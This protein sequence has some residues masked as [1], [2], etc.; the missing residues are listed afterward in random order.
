MNARIHING[1]LIRSGYGDCDPDDDGSEYFEAEVERV[2]DDMC[3]S[4]STVAEAIKELSEAGD[5]WLVNA[6]ALIVANPTHDDHVYRLQMQV[7]EH[8]Y[9]TR[10]EAAERR[11]EREWAQHHADTLADRYYDERA[12]RG[13]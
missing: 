13:F 7:E 10:R 12:D 8:I 6:L 2:L 4:A 9:R 3:R 11:V 5:L 1:P